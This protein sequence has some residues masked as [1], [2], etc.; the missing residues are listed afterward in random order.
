LK[1]RATRL[2]PKRDSKR[3]YLSTFS[4]RSALSSLLGYLLAMAAWQSVMTYNSSFFGEWFGITVGEVSI[5]ILFGAL[6]YTLGSIACGRIVNKVSRKKLMVLFTL[7]LSVLVMSYTQM[8]SFLASG[9]VLCLAC[10]FGGIMYAASTNLIMEQLPR[11]AG[12]MMS[13][14]RAVTHVEFSIGA[15]LGGTL[16]MLHG[17]QRM[18]LVLGALA[19]ASA[20]VFRFYTHD[21][22]PEKE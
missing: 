9:G 4:N 10:L 21:G 17:Y 13:L 2:S 12:T 19:L 3:V 22:T 16:L 20:V 15:G 18:F 8:P 7:G 11:F 6:L 1:L 14:S 5:M